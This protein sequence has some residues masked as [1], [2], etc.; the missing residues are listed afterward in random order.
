MKKRAWID[1]VIHFNA[2]L[3]DGGDG[4]WQAPGSGQS[5]PDPDVE[6]TY[7]EWLEI[8]SDFP[9]ILDFDGDG[10]MGTEADYQAWYQRYFGN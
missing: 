6:W 5:T 10:N 8:Y 7:A 1:P 3:G 9:E 2:G 4:T